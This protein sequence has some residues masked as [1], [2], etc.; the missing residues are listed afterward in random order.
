VATGRAKL[1]AGA[2]LATEVP[3]ARAGVDPR[4]P[5]WLAP[6][7]GLLPRGH[8]LPMPTAV[9]QARPS[10]RPSRR[11]QARSHPLS[12]SLP[13]GR[14]RARS[15]LRRRRSVHCGAG[16]TRDRLRSRRG[17]SSA[18]AWENEAELRRRPSSMRRR[19]RSPPSSDPGDARPRLRRGVLLH[20]GAAAAYGLPVLLQP[21]AARANAAVARPRGLLGQC[22][23]AAGK[24]DVV[25]SPVLG[26]KKGNRAHPDTWGLRSR[27]PNH[28][29][30]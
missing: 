10:T 28:R 15:C 18:T 23:E 9:S 12:V 8:P 1:G 17:R 24:T 29:Q 4:G 19:H 6:A 7:A 27:H 20:P 13:I 5:L 21:H 30:N 26:E 2:V 16:T 14:P 22:R 25:R 11:G 3:V